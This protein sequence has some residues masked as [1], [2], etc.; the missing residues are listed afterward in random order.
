LKYQE[1]MAGQQRVTLADIARVPVEVAYIDQGNRNSE[2]VLVLLHGIPTWSYLYSDVLSLI[3]DDYRVIAV[4]FLGHGYSERRDICDRSLEVQAVMVRSLLAHLGID[5]V[6]LVGHDTGGGVA[7]ILAIDSPE[8]LQTM[9]ISNAV[10]YDSWPI[11]DMIQLGDPGWK[12]KPPEEI[13][14]FVRAGLPD[15]I[16]RAHR[17]TDEWQ[18]GIIA[19][20][21]DAEGALSLIRNAASLN[22][23]HTSALT[24]LLSTITT[25]TLLLWGVDDPWQSFEDALRLHADIP[26]SRLVAVEHASHWLPRDAPEEFV[27]ALRSFIG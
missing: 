12:A 8:I 27:E 4:D 19:P 25:P 15:G 1:F 9:T 24:A 7:L 14:A 17:L 11:E 10:A 16:S 23:N 2:K 21:S 5:S 18:D 22:T 13:A 20:Y 3:A 6:H 26:D